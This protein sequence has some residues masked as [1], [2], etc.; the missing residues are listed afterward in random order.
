MDDMKGMD[1]K[2][3]AGHLHFEG[4]VPIKWAAPNPLEF[5]DVI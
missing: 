3:I 5:E 4:S 2:R 1:V